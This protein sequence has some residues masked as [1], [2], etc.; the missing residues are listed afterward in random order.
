MASSGPVADLSEMQVEPQ[1]YSTLSVSSYEVANSV[2]PIHINDPSFIDPELSNNSSTE[3]LLHL[4]DLSSTEPAARDCG[5]T[6][7]NTQMQTSSP[8]YP[9]ASDCAN[10]KSDPVNELTRELLTL[11]RSPSPSFESNALEQ[12]VEGFTPEELIDAILKA[13]VSGQ[14]VQ[15]KYPPNLPSFLTFATSILVFE[16]TL[17]HWTETLELLSE[18]LNGV[19][20]LGLVSIVLPLVALS[21]KGGLDIKGFM[22]KYMHGGTHKQPPLPMS[23]G[24]S[25]VFQLLVDLLIIIT[26]LGLVVFVENLHISQ[27]TDWKILAPNL[28]RFFFSFFWRQT[29]SWMCLWMNM[30]FSRKIGSMVKEFVCRQ[31]DIPYIKAHQTESAPQGQITDLGTL[32]KFICEQLSEEQIEILKQEQELL[33]KLDKARQQ[34]HECHDQ[35]TDLATRVA[36]IAKEKSSVG[37]GLS[38]AT[39]ADMRLLMD[40]E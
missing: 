18:I 26:E 39:M 8:Q 14:P 27:T 20:W 6:E 2:E 38:E 36:K 17:I 3:L 25:M 21:I 29:L 9:E 19:L 22:R 33:T 23:Q 24:L 7:S 12:R 11:P 10:T 13:K 5:I 40:V 32:A 31:T 4:E 35:V 34:L 15:P 30:A 1:A 28:K 37:T 16:Y